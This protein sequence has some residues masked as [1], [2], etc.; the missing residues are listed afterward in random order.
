[1]QFP[2]MLRRVAL[3][4]TYI[5]YECFAS[6]IRVTAIGQLGTS[7]I[8]SN[9]ST[10]RATRRNIPEDGIHHSHRHKYLKSYMASTGWAL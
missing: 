8:S 4:K 3:V 10:Q 7:A 1:M 5:S 9:R 2:G 6:I